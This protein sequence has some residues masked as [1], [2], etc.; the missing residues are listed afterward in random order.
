MSFLYGLEEAA[1]DAFNFIEEY[2][3]GPA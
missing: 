1:P 3:T 2:L